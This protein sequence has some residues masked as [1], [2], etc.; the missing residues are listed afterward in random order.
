MRYRN[1][2]WQPSYTKSRLWFVKFKIDR[3]IK[4]KMW[5]I[6]KTVGFYK[7]QNVLYF[8]IMYYDFYYEP[9]DNQVIDL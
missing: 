7:T 2:F 6:S 4:F 3:C 5:N 8:L 1:V 9:K